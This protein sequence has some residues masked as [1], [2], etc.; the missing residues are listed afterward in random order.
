MNRAADHDYE[1]VLIAQAARI[2]RR[3]MF[4]MQHFDEHCQEDSVPPMLKLWVNM[5][6]DGPGKN[7][8]ENKKTRFFTGATSVSNVKSYKKKVCFPEETEQVS[9][10]NIR[11]DIFQLLVSK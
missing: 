6:L 2:V 7:V 10:W 9:W 1:A 8:H 11:K 5:T 4:H 3:E